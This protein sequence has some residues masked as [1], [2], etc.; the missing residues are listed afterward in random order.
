VVS[1]QNSCG[2]CSRAHLRAAVWQVRRVKPGEIQTICL[3]R[4][5]WDSRL[6]AQYAAAK[7]DYFLT[8][9]YFLARAAASNFW[10]RLSLTRSPPI[11]GARVNHKRGAS[12]AAPTH[13]IE[14]N[15]GVPGPVPS[16]CGAASRPNGPRVVGRIQPSSILPAAAPCVCHDAAD[17][18]LAVCE[19]GAGAAACY[20]SMQFPQSAGVFGP[21]T[22]G[23]VVKPPRHELWMSPAAD[24]RRCRPA[25][26]GPVA[27]P[28]SSLLACSLS[29]RVQPP[30]RCRYQ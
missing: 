15:R 18:R 13:V 1:L 5:E 19:R 28:V 14:V 21:W 29:P 20:R 6:I 24:D 10:L 7:A 30:C 2:G 8:F 22:T 23:S 27:T 17:G 9:Y 3:S 25:P 16:W 4:G 11:G 26:L 12:G